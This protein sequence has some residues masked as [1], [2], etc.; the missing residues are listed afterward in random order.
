MFTIMA[1]AY[2]GIMSEASS[3]LKVGT[4]VFA[5]SSLMGYFNKGKSPI[6]RLCRMNLIPIALTILT[7]AEMIFGNGSGLGMLLMT[8]FTTIYLSF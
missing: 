6:L 1:E 8:L 4:L 5:L 2:F 3:V 7:I